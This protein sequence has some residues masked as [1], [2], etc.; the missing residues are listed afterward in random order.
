M[1]FNL[2]YVS[3]AFYKDKFAERALVFLFLCSVWFVAHKYLG[4]HHDGIFYSVQA[5][6]HLYPENFKNDLFFFG[7]SQDDFT[8]F[9]VFYGRIIKCLDLETGTFIV[10]LL[11]SFFL[12][13]SLCLLCFQLFD[14]RVGVLSVIAVSLLPACYGSQNLLSYGEPFLTART[15]AE[16]FALL[17]IYFC[18]REKHVFAFFAILFSILNHPIIA[19]PAAMFLFFYCVGLAHPRITLILIA[20]GVSLLLSNYAFLSP[21]NTKM[22]AEWYAITLSRSPFIF[23]TTWT[24]AE[25][26]RVIV[27]HIL[28]LLAASY[29]D[30]KLKKCFVAMFC[31]G[32]LGVAM[33][34]LGDVSR[35]ALLLQMQPWRVLWLVQLFSVLALSYVLIRYISESLRSHK[36]IACMAAM[37]FML[38]AYGG[39]VIA[40]LT[41][42]YR[43]L[44]KGGRFEPTHLIEKFLLFVSIL[45]CAVVAFVYFGAAEEYL[46]TTSGV[47]DSSSI[48]F[49]YKLRFKEFIGAFYIFIM[50]VCF[51]F[52]VKSKRLSFLTLVCVVNFIGLFF[53]WDMRD[54]REKSFLTQASIYQA[55]LV[56][57][58]PKD[59]VVLLVGGGSS[60]EIS[61]FLNMR[62]H[63]ASS[64]QLAGGVF[65]RKTSIEGR[66]RLERLQHAGIYYEC[67]TWKGCFEGQA[68]TNIT[69]ILKKKDFIYLCQD[70][71][72]DYIID[73][74]N[75]LAFEGRYLGIYPY[76]NKEK[77]YLYSCD[78]IRHFN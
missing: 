73:N 61:W 65:S 17:S 45:M 13:C 77:E 67:M 49:L 42:V 36:V 59:A 6:K 46:T 31:S 4:V 76:L 56:G 19:L 75:I 12:F 41:L 11:G 25:I 33:A 9:T 27:A 55:Q 72:L 2:R 63:Y 40:I 48:S 18:V 37:S 15:L 54:L 34:C 3:S 74:Q 14:R 64:L 22:D 32:L 1:R 24:F 7:R 10:H 58:V 38:S 57:L 8:I 21:I 70:N 68:D 66:R 29:A 23:I 78:A 28:I 5:L 51:W 52:F 20:L 62:S 53:L 60:A 69:P 71:A 35:N 44:C 47:Q 43:W 39:G 30:E 50:P 26:S 16:P